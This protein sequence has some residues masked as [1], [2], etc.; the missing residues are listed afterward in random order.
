MNI[1][2]ITVNEHGEIVD[3]NLRYKAAKMLGFSDDQIPMEKVNTMEK[4]ITEHSLHIFDNG[5][6]TFDRYTIVGPYGNVWGASKNPFHPQGFGQFSHNADTDYDKIGREQLIKNFREE[7][8]VGKEISFDDCPD[9]V[10]EFILQR[11]CGYDLSDNQKAFIQEIYKQN[12]DIDFYYS[13]PEEML[14]H[15]PAVLIDDVNDIDELL[16]TKSN[17]KMKKQGYNLIVYAKN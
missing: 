2:P 8:Q 1:P 12:L 14:D 15:C 9:K 13:P 16:P 4:E 3:G 7:G 10:Q 5:G 6:E 11:I 17:T